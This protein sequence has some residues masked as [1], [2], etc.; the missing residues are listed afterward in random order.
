MA[1]TSVGSA[2]YCDVYHHFYCKRYFVSVEVASSNQGSADCHVCVLSPRCFVL[3]ADRAAHWCAAMRVGC[4]ARLAKRKVAKG[5]IPN[6]PGC[7]GLQHPIIHQ[8]MPSPNPVKKPLKVR[9]F[10][11]IL[12]FLSFLC[13]ARD[14]ARPRTC[15]DNLQGID[16]AKQLWAMRLHKSAKDVPAWKDLT[17]CGFFRDRGLPSCPQGGDYTIGAVEQPASCSIA[18]HTAYYRQHLDDYADERAT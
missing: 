7:S 6:P 16:A 15:L 1:A 4:S 2:Y 5:L 17:D 18:K 10:L 3:V 12:D 13:R 9:I 14:S 8:S 11:A